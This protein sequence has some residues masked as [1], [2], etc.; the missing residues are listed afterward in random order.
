MLGVVCAFL[1]ADA[2]KPITQKLGVIGLNAGVFANMNQLISVCIAFA[3][4]M[5]VVGPL[6]GL[7][8]IFTWKTMK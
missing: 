1:L 4:T 2:G 8:E 6:A 3:L 5:I 7:T